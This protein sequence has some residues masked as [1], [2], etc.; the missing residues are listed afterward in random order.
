MHIL[1]SI[2]LQLFFDMINYTRSRRQYI[3]LFDFLNHFFS[4]ND[5]TIWM[6]WLDALIHTDQSYSSK[7]PQTG[8]HPLALAV[9][10]DTPS[11]PQPSPLEE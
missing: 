3:F 6:R 7:Y 5:Y 10:G 2:L 8:Y 1:N 11:G 9:L 4:V